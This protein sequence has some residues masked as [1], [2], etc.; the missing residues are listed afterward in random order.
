[1]RNRLHALASALAFCML[2]ALVW[3]DPPL[4]PSIHAVLLPP[5]TS[6]GSA[7]TPMDN[8]VLLPPQTFDGSAKAP[9]T[10][11]ERYG[12]WS[13]TGGVYLIQPV[14]ESNPASVVIPGVGHVT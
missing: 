13:I 6:D 7:K 9:N 12:Q 4:T 10:T 2:P 1:M 11:R 8:A 3:A 5:Q 14:F